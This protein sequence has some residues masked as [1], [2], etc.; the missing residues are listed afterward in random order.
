MCRVKAS[1]DIYF[2]YM[3]GTKHEKAVLV[4]LSYIVGITSGFIAFGL[5]QNTS[6]LQTISPNIIIEETPQ[7]P[8]ASDN[9]ESE[10]S[11]PNE[12]PLEIPSANPVQVTYQDGRLIVD[13]NGATQILSV[14]RSRLNQEAASY[15]TKQGM[16]T[17]EPIFVL[18]PDN[19]FVYFCEQAATTDVC[20]SLVYD[21]KN[22]MIN[23][24][25]NNGVKVALTRAEAQQVS[26]QGSLLVSGTNSSDSTATPWL[27]STK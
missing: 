19:N 9:M 1:N 27:L 13:V 10:F 15:F 17:I 26:W 5:T 2:I 16:H 3:E 12:M 18:S 22:E 7:T 21:I 6:A 8:V 11:K 23:Y 20:Q 24:V 25:S 14:E 4:V